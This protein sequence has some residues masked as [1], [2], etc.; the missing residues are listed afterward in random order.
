[1]INVKNVI[2]CFAIPGLKGFSTKS[3]PVNLIAWLK[4]IKVLAILSLRVW[5]L[6]LTRPVKE[7]PGNS[8]HCPYAEAH[9]FHTSPM[10]GFR[11]RE[12]R[13]DSTYKSANCSSCL[14]INFLTF[15]TRLIQTLFN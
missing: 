11:V 5:F 3:S 15:Y 7:I 4:E 10:G 1:M 6:L 2:L 14:L 13:F 8:H 9:N 12:V